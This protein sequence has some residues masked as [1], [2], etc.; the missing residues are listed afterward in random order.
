MAEGID[1]LERRAPRLDPKS[2]QQL[3]AV[4]DWL[5][6]KRPGPNVVLVARVA[7]YQYHQGPALEARFAAG[8]PLTLASEP[9]N[10]HDP[11]AVRLLWEGRK[12]GYVPRPWN[13][14]IAA[15]LLAGEPLAAE[16]T[17]FHSDAQPW[18][19]LVFE[20]R[21]KAGAMP[22]EQPLD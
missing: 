14:G 5:E 15:R 10:P 20:V 13:A 2:E 22:T 4:L 3:D 21:R 16:I 11:M 19:R 9:D 8:Q 18:K 6:M 12:I 1:V 7:G 17:D